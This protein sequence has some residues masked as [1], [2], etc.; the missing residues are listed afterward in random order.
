MQGKEHVQGFI[1]KFPNAAEYK[2]LR[3]VIV[4]YNVQTLHTYGTKPIPDTKFCS[5]IRIQ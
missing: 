3:N 1:K 5:K 2:I 4:Q